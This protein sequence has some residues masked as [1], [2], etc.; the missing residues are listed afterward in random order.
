MRAL[1]RA[2]TNLYLRTIHKVSRYIRYVPKFRFFRRGVQNYT[3]FEVFRKQEINTGL[4]GSETSMFYSFSTTTSNVSFFPLGATRTTLRVVGSRVV[5]DAPFRRRMYCYSENKYL[6]LT[7]DRTE[8][9]NFSI[10][11]TRTKKEMNLCTYC[12]S[13]V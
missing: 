13:L 5:R 4:G 12:P 3:F 9:G 11:R 8:L 2:W 7:I 10:T 6:E 1:N